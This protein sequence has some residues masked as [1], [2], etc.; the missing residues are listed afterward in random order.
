MTLEVTRCCT[1]GARNGCSK[2][3]GAA[4]RATRA[5]GYR[6]LLTYIL[7]S[8]AGASLRASGWR[9]VGIRGGG[10]WNCPSRPR[11]ETPTKDRNCSGR[12]IHEHRTVHP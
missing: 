7:A 4:W 1:D 5:L 12:C 11:V 10:S 6:R 8:E 3:Y 9:L 2:L